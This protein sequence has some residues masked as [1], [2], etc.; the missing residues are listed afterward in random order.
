MAS[1]SCVFITNEQLKSKKSEAKKG[2]KACFM[3]KWD[4]NLNYLLEILTQRETQY[5]QI[6]CLNFP[7]TLFCRKI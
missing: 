4:R 7:T 1:I 6:F 2:I 3:Q 5:T